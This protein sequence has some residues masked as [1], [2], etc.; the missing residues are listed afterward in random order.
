M[1]DISG[2]E[3]GIAYDYYKGLI[4]GARLSI[5]G[6]K[7]LIDSN[8]NPSSGFKLDASAVYE[9]NDFI[10]GLNLSD[11]GTLLPNY[12]NNNLWRFEQSSSL[13]FTIPK[14]N[15]ITINLESITGIITNTKV[16]SFFNFFA[17]GLNG[18]KGY[19]FYSIEGNA[20]AV[21]SSTLRFPFLGKNI[22][23]LDG[24]LFKIALLESLVKLEM[25]GIIKL[26]HRDG[27]VQL[28]FNLE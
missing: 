16:D 13:Y 27:I 7:R 28:V 23:L 2:L 17:G 18:L 15:R 5:N 21:F 6:I 26:S 22:F 24:L 9:K 20:M 4:S 14:T 19:P 25:H 3:A 12:S 10:E 8:I 1:I 11:A